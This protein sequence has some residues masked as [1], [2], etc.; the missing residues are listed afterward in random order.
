MK[1][2]ANSCA[3]GGAS[4][5]R[6][7]WAGTAAASV[8][9]RTTSAHRIGPCSLPA[10]QRGNLDPGEVLGDRAEDLRLAEDPRVDVELQRVE[11]PL[12]DQEVELEAVCDPRPGRHRA[13]H[14]LRGAGRKLDLPRGGDLRSLVL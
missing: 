12:V 8:T 3:G 11:L 1:T 14:E 5:R 10:V 9:A 2:R 4:T 6:S 13:R 7:A